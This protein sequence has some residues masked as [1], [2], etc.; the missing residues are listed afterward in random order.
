MQLMLLLLQRM[1]P[2]DVGQLLHPDRLQAGHLLR[3]QAPVVVV[4]GL[5]LGG[6]QRR[7]QAGPVR[8]DAR[9][10]LRRLR[11]QLGDGAGELL[12]GA[13]VKLVRQL[14]AIRV[15]LLRQR[16]DLPVED[17]VQAAHGQRRH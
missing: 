7:L 15:R 2:K 13:G 5:L 14:G 11:L 8:L 9:P 12:L 6:G 17:A 4:L 3:P 16:L 1:G 10:Q